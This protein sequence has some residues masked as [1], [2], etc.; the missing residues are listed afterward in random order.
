MVPVGAPPQRAPFFLNS[1]VG[2][3]TLDF[4]HAQNWWNKGGLSKRM[5]KKWLF[6][7]VRSYLVGKDF[8]ERLLKRGKEAREKIKEL[9]R[10]GVIGLGKNLL[11]Q[12]YD[13]M[14][15]IYD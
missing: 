5:H 14:P 8:D 2:N 11:Q 13:R 9:G 6:E 4:P 3:F 10:E 7:I 15:R 1:Q 12:R